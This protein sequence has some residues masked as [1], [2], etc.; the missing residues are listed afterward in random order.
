MLHHCCSLLLLFL[1]SGLLYCAWI[2]RY[3]GHKG[4][5]YKIDSA[6]T[7][8]DACVVSG[9]ENITSLSVFWFA[10]TWIV[11]YKGHKGEYKIDCTDKHSNDACVVTCGWETLY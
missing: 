9:W 11:R 7:H 6:L 8:D 2:V 5:E 1:F 10:V 4:S 3:K